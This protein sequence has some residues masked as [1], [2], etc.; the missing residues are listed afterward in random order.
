LEYL[1]EQYNDYNRLYGKSGT[2]KFICAGLGDWGVEQNKGRGRG[3]VETAFYYRDLMVMAEI[4][5]VLAKTAEMSRAADGEPT[6]EADGETFFLTDAEEFKRQAKEV[7]RL[8]NEA[9][10]VIEEASDAEGGTKKSNVRAYYKTYDPK[11]ELGVTQANQAIPLCFGLVPEEDIRGV[12]A[13]LVSLCEGKHLVC[14][15]VG[16]VYI[17]RALAAAGR[18]DIILDMITK[19]EHPSYLRFV[20]QGETTL[21]EFWRDDA[22]S[23][24]HDMMGHIMEWYFTEVAGIKGDIGFKAVTIA[25]AKELVD[26]FICE[27]DSIRGKIRVMYDGGRLKVETPCNVAVIVPGGE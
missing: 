19:T 2:E 14:G 12:E 3:N 5:G 8:Y 6:V 7:R 1:T 4:A 10:L 23:R 22:R 26:S 9:L 16:L 18:N 21:P 27:Y 11:E 25:P 17:L 24:N 20:E 13:T 15:E